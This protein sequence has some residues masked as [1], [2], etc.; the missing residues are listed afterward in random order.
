MGAERKCAGGG[1]APCPS[2]E[3]LDVMPRYSVWP[4]VVAACGGGGG[5]ASRS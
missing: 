4:L 3:V 5:G 1:G 2:Y